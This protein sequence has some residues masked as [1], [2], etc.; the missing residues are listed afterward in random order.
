MFGINTYS[1]LFSCKKY[2][3]VFVAPWETWERSPWTISHKTQSAPQ[4]KTKNSC[5]F[6]AI[7]V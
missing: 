7:C 6:Y 4:G 1:L 3:K 2:T 5:N